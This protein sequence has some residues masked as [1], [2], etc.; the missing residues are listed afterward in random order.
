MK[1]LTTPTS[2]YGRVPRAVIIER[3]L[4]DRVDVEFVVTRTPDSAIWGF[5]PAG[6]VPSLVVDDGIVVSETK[7]ICGI[8]DT[9]HDA[10]PVLESYS[11]PS[12]LALEGLIVAFVDSASV[13]LR[14]LRRPSNER[15]PGIIQHEHDRAVRVLDS[16]EV[17][18]GRLDQ[19]L[20]YRQLL[21]ASIL[22]RMGAFEPSVNWPQCCP[23][24]S[25]WSAQYL[26]RPSLVASR[27]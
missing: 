23:E 11:D 9:L 18:V 2:P 27:A 15:S 5:N 10:E 1:L 17:M 24:L 12:E 3:D 16:L 7:L 22:E 13:W 20:T 26:S 6:K 21:L 8:L 25:Q 14:E 19:R 4:S